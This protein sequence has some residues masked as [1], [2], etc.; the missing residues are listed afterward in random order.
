MKLNLTPVITGQT[1][2][3]IIEAFITIHRSNGWSNHRSFYHYSQ[4]KQLG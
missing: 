4:V 1:A 3:L 2:G